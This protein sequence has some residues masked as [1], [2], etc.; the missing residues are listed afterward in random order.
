MWFG[1]H[2]ISVSLIANLQLFDTVQGKDLKSTKSCY[3]KFTEN[4]VIFS[5]SINFFSWKNKPRV[6]LHGTLL[7]ISFNK[8]LY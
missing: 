8:V 4:F 5:Q 2:I 1:V 3:T 7:Y 6:N